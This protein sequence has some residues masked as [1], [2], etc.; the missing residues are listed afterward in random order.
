MNKIKPL[1]LKFNG[2]QNKEYKCPSPQ[3]PVSP[4][5]E[6]ITFSNGGELYVGNRQSASI[7]RQKY[8]ASPTKLIYN[9]SKYI[10]NM[11]YQAIDLSGPDNSEG[12]FSKD[13]ISFGELLISYSKIISGELLSGSKVLIMCDAGISRSA[14]MAI[15]VLMYLSQCQEYHD[16]KDLDPCR[17]PRGEE[18]PIDD[19]AFIYAKGKRKIIDP[20]IGF[21]WLLFQFRKSLVC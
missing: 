3:T 14:S 9:F 2:L 7:F 17:I 21:R 18:P 13:Q 15:A 20:N 12:V 11:E 6:I 5:T 1:N 10:D 19:P 8:P 4:L 16:L